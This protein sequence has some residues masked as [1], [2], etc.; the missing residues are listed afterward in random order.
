MNIYVGNLPYTIGEDELSEIFGKY[1]AVNSVKI[2][3]DKYSGRSKGFGFVEMLNDEEAQKAVDELND[4][5][6]KGRNVKV[7][8]ARE[9]KTDDRDISN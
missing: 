7:N 4:T 2:I 6:F 3:T 9:K 1:G 8:V 5:D